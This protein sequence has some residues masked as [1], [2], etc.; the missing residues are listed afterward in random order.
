MEYS[1]RMIL[2]FRWIARWWRNVTRENYVH[3]VTYTKFDDVQYSTC[4]YKMEDAIEYAEGL[5]RSGKAVY[6]TNAELP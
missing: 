1:S 5:E 2:M 4:F 3:I 6:I